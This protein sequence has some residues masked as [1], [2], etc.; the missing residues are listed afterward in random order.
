MLKL[1][2]VKSSEKDE[3][4]SKVE[5][6]KKLCV[7]SK[8]NYELEETFLYSIDTYLFPLPRIDGHNSLGNLTINYE[9]I[10]KKGLIG[11]KTE[12]EA[13]IQKYGNIKEKSFLNSLLEIIECIN[14]KREKDLNY[15]KNL[16]AIHPQ[17]E[18]IKSLIEIF[19]N[20]PL[21]PAK[22]FKEALQSF[23][24]INSLIWIDRHPLVGLGRLDQIFYPFFENDFNK[25]VM[26]IKESYILIK[27]FLKSINKY[28]KYKSNTLFGDTGQVMVLGGKKIDGRDAS[29][30]LTFQFIDALK[31][32]KKPDPKIVLRIHK[33]TSPEL[34]QKSLECL[35]T[36]LG[37]PLFSNDEIVI[38]SL[39]D[40]GYEKEDAYQYSTSAC[41]EPLISGRSS[42]QNNLANI[43]FLEPLNRVL[44]EVKDEDVKN[45]DDFL[46]LYEKKL[47][48]YIE[49]IIQKIDEIKFEKSPLLSLLTEDCIKNSQDISEGGAK[50][51]HIGLLT[52]ALGNTVNALL[53][54]KK[55]VFIDKKLKITE[56]YSI[57]ENNFRLNEVLRIELQNKG[58]KYGMEKEK[59]IELTNRLIDVVYNK[60]KDF[61]TIYG[62]KYKFGL[63]SPGFIMES[64]NYPAS[65]DGR[66][67]NEPFGV[68]ISPINTSN[69]SYTEIINFASNLFYQ[70]SFNGG[71]VDIMVEKSFFKKFKKKFITFLMVSFKKGIMQMQINVLNPKILIQARENP[72]I[73]PNL[74]V[75]VWG[76]STYFNDLPDEYKDLIIERALH[77]ESANH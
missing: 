21:Y 5:I 7:E 63:S 61:K 36:G 55:L 75:R 42:D 2:F 12:I 27:E 29:N 68:H 41:W 54:I 40:F 48:V 52:L 1:Q 49:E 77:Y 71:V 13:E 34:W 18:N 20:I 39:I 60:L 56:I 16:S 59:V 15:L 9:K 46:S 23:L 65:F 66:K 17:N 33:G 8:I 19:S 70:K 30:Q 62:H 22:T 67:D 10:L 44:E 14:I 76:F 3:L 43:N 51:N 69:L 38:S 35:E 58:L 45:Y 24:F 37:Y 4:K 32:L 11:L 47:E 57:I 6:F 74:I 72:E 64:S 50:Y 26:D 31:E 53:N 28:Y 73:H 25:G